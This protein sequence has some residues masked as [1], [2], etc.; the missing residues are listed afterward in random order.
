MG[1][2][3][4]LQRGHFPQNGIL[5]TLQLRTAAVRAFQKLLV[6]LQERERYNKQLATQAQH[7]VYPIVSMGV[8]NPGY[9]VYERSNEHLCNIWLTRNIVAYMY[10]YFSGG[11]LCQ[12]VSI[13]CYCTGLT[14]E[15]K[16]QKW[17]AKHHSVKQGGSKQTLELW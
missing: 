13:H 2:T 5:L 4:S 10:T 3:Q 7:G 15:S 9:V 8:S 12:G 6:H 1:G 16:P 11:Q 17:V 14:F